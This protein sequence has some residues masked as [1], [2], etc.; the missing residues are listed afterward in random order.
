[1]KLAIQGGSPAF[2]EGPPSWPPE[3]PS[4]Q[5][6]VRSALADGSWGRYHGPHV[7]ALET[8][9][10][11]LHSVRHALSVCSGTFAV[12]L[13]LRIL[14]L[15][16]DAEVLLAGYDFPG[17]F[18]A[19]EA[20]GAR[21]VLVD[22]DPQTW[23]LDAGRIEQAVSPATRA[24]I[25][26][27]LHGGLADMERVR[28]VA[29]EQQ[30]LVVEDACQCPGAV[31]QGRPAGSWGDVGVLSFGGSKLLTAGRGGAILTD[32][33]DLAQR[34]KIFCERGNHAYPLSEVQ[35]ALLLPQL[36]LLAE[37]NA[38]RRESVE[39]LLQATSQ[40]RLLRP[41]MAPAGTPSYYK[42]AW[43]LGD[44]DDD[45]PSREEF[46]RA[47]QAE[48]VA[49]DAGF[50]GFARRSSRRCRKSGDLPHS[51]AAAER[52]VIL[53][54]PILLGSNPQIDRLADAICAV[55]DHFESTP[56]S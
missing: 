28:R 42:L 16:P 6:A 30:L 27:H 45:S 47:I 26:S 29:A 43:L 22:V 10:A 51:Q 5:E 53:H 33:D 44:L 48:G 18:R 7:A 21:P 41:V 19:V 8:G 46:L 38:A 49:M 55:A 15:P 36:E 56:R 34:A 24:I 25:V 14:K 50:R 12:E 37:R 31:V 9:L 52:T 35:A 11:K 1:M 4:V 2:P 39:R 40:V 54:H 32:S 20:S 13:A 23:C 3:E 17:N